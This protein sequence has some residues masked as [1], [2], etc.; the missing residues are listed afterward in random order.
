MHG[1]VLYC[2]ISRTDDL[3]SNLGVQHQSFLAEP[4]GLV[5]IYADLY[6]VNVQ[7]WQAAKI[8]LKVLRSDDLLIRVM[9]LL[10]LSF[11]LFAPVYYQTSLWDV[12]LQNYENV[13]MFLHVYIY[14]LLKKK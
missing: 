13:S 6:V 7:F 10:K 12:H 9:I 5:D 1:V 3:I 2:Y 8:Y 14:S 11:K 4:R